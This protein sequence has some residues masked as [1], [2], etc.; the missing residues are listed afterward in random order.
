MNKRK[1]V[2]LS[3]A[4]GTLSIV[5]F[6]TLVFSSIGGMA[7]EAITFYKC[8]APGLL[9]Q[10]SGTRL[11]ALPWSGYAVCYLSLCSGHQFSA[12]AAVIPLKVIHQEWD[13][14]SHWMSSC[15]RVN[16]WIWSSCK[17]SFVQSICHHQQCETFFQLP[18]PH[19]YIYIYFTFIIILFGSCFSSGLV[20]TYFDVTLNVCILFLPSPVLFRIFYFL[21]YYSFCCCKTL[22]DQSR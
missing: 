1:S 9:W 20:L 21:F 3:S 19:Q 11:I 8:L 4:S 17:F 14:L 13:L 7:K 12:F 6:L 15:R 22:I 16:G 18:C 5:H 2:T 10:R